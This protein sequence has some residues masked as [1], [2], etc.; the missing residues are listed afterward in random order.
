MTRF[1]PG[2]IQKPA[3]GDLVTSFAWN[4]E[5]AEDLPS[6][7]FTRN[8]VVNVSTTSDGTTFWDQPAKANELRLA[9]MRRVENFL[10]SVI[11]DVNDWTTTG[12]TNTGADATGN[13]VQ[14]PLGAT[15]ATQ[16]DWTGAFQLIR[17]RIISSQAPDDVPFAISFS[18]RIESGDTQQAILHEVGTQFDLIAC[19]GAWA[20][21]AVNVAPPAGANL[22]C[23]IQNRNSPASGET[24]VWGAMIEYAQDLVNFVASEI[25]DVA[26]TYNAQVQAVRYYNTTNE[27]TA[28]ANGGGAA[29]KVTE[30]AGN[31]IEDG[32]YLAEDNS[33]P[34]V[35]DTGISID[36][37]FGLLVDLTLPAS[38]T[39]TAT[40][41]GASASAVDILRADSL[42]NIIM[43]AGGTPVTIGASSASARVRVAYGQDATGRSGSLNGATAVTGGAPSASHEGENFQIACRAGIN[44]SNAIHHLTNVYVDRPTDEQL[45]TVSTPP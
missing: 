24:H 22:T 15:D 20:Q 41:I 44:Q 10:D 34:D 43:D 11:N 3:T 35:L 13:A 21:Y 12:W 8:S 7:T 27:N 2:F 25:V 1:S 28:T 17:A 26:T 33:P 18:C 4:A 42:F 5:L 6:G 37:E 39:G 38:I 9:K 16:I 32:G 45:E 31:L 36:D 19:D 23:A 14:G 30:V 40:L 29:Y